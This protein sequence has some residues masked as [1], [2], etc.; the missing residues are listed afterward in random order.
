MYTELD[1]ISQLVNQ[2]AKEGRVPG[3][4]HNKLMHRRRVLSLSQGGFYTM[5][6]NGGS[7]GKPKPKPPPIDPGME[8][9]QRCMN[10][11][12]TLRRSRSLAVR[13]FA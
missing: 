1:A 4:Y 6:G 12:I 3:T 2:G 9:H 7:G 11:S 5:G 10:V 8:L 13:L